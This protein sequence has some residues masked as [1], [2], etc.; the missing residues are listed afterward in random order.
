MLLIRN[1]SCY[2]HDWNKQRVLDIH[3]YPFRE[4]Y[5]AVV[6]M[7]EEDVWT[8]G[9]VRYVYLDEGLMGMPMMSK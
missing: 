7:G 4:G 2:E 8:S 1:W 3:S 6:I 5:D 9:A